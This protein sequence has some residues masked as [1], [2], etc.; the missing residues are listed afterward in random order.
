MMMLEGAPA[1]SNRNEYGAITLCTG[2]SFGV[3]TVVDRRNIFDC[4]LVVR[5][6]L[7]EWT[8][9]SIEEAEAVRVVGRCRELIEQLDRSGHR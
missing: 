5:L 6:V 9:K 3:E 2:T 7:P 1:L 4:S 8:P